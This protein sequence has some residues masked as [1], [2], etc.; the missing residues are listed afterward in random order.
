MKW[1]VLIA[2]SNAELCDIYQG[3]LGNFGFEVVTASDGLECVEQLRQVNPAVLVLDWEILWG[4]G[5]GILAWLGENRAHSD[6]R[7]VVAGTRDFTP[8]APDF[9]PRVV[10]IL[11][12]PMHLT[13]LLE[14][15]HAALPERGRAEPS[16]DRH[17]P[18]AF[19]DQAFDG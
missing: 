6:V 16:F 4:G 9:N 15:V 19:S 13:S 18:T 8:H 14:C 7:V 17:R 12:K 3:F 5:D 2:E 1:P 10:H 11:P